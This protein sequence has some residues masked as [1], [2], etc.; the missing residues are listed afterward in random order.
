MEQSDTPQPES[1]LRKTSKSTSKATIR[2][3]NNEKEHF[4]T[5][6]NK[7]RTIRRLNRLETIS[8][9]SESDQ[10]LAVTQNEIIQHLIYPYKRILEYLVKKGFIKE[11]TKFCK[12][13]TKSCYMNAL[14]GF[15][16]NFYYAFV[17]KAVISLAMGL[18]N[19]SKKLVKNIL[20]LLTK[21]CLSF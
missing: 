4:D 11:R 21:D 12:H 8:E 13:A 3:N 7:L 2:R 17:A 6:A 9:V 20:S 10:H 1:S 19:P 14:E 18:L 5:T 15:G 16:K